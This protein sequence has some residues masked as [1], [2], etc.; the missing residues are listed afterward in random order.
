MSSDSNSSKTLTAEVVT[1]RLRE[2]S[3]LSRG[4]RGRPA[5]DMSPAAVTARLRELSELSELCTRLGELGRAARASD[6][7]HA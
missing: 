4:Y 2:L 1:A 6:P 5:V 7:T 3:E